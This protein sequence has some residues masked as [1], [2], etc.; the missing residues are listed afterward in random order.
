MSVLK[1]YYGVVDSFLL[2][3]PTPM[4]I[5]YMWGFGSMLGLCLVVQVVSGFLLS[6]LYACGSSLSF[7]SVV[8]I[9]V[10]V[11][12]GWVVR[13]VHSSGAS[14][15]M[16]LMYVHVLRG[17]W[18]GSFKKASVWMLG[19]VVLVVMSLVSFLGYVLPWGQMSFWAATVI[20]SMVTAVPVVGEHLSWWLWGAFSVGDPTLVRFFSLHYMM[21]L[22]VTIVV[23]MHLI[24]LHESGSGNPV[25]C[26]SVLDKLSFHPL[27]SYK[28]VLGLTW[29]MW[30]YIAVVCADPLMV[31]DS[32]NYVESSPM[33][34][35]SH[36]KPEW[37]FLYAY[38]ILRSVSSK[39]GGVVLMVM[40]MLV[41]LV[42]VVTSVWGV[43]VNPV[44]G[45]SGWLVYM[46]VWSF[47]GLTILGGHP[48]EYPY[49]MLGEVMTAVYFMSVLMI[50]LVE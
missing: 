11:N 36:I 44:N 43:S 48:V 30:L 50:V 33:K 10:D 21:A 17:L 35:P 24:N 26:D 1:L 32:S 37:Y 5:N 34:T 19:V 39:V 9:M 42:P 45:A 3:L 13:Y 29:V 27:F 6:L 41:L 18:Y 22:A 8:S 2:S 40:G 20:T 46:V 12:Y 47:I 23:L 4:S 16:L 49:Q 28:D 38:C 25:G 7:Y 14:L 31:M 15:L